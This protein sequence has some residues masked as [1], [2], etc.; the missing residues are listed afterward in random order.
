MILLALQ[1]GEVVDAL[2][3]RQQL[4]HAGPFEQRQQAGGAG[5][6]AEHADAGVPQSGHPEGHAL[7]STSR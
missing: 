1:N 6:A 5:V 2:V 7:S 4:V 3:G